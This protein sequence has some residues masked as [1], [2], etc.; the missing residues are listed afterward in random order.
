MALA[1][2]V[3]FSDYARIRPSLPRAPIC[4]ALSDFRGP[5]SS[6]S[7]TPATIFRGNMPGDVIGPY[8]SQFLWLD[9]PMGALLIPQKMNTVPGGVDY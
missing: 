9:V 8:L 4:P 6:G 1:R 5:T 7:V 3:H 2:D